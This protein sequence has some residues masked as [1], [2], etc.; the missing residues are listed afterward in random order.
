MRGQARHA[1][2]LRLLEPTMP[3]KPL[4]ES[5]REPISSTKSMRAY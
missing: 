1:A 2:D 3:L 5:M 4:D